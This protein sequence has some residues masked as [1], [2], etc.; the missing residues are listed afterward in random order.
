ML[1]GVIMQFITQ[2]V[3]N[4]ITKYYLK[5]NLAKDELIENHAWHYIILLIMVIGVFGYAFYCTSKG[6]DFVG[7]VSLRSGFRIECRKWV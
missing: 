4:S 2:Y 5:L 7:S 6:Y 1:K 3:N